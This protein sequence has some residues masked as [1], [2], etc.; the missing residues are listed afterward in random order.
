MALP[1]NWTLPHQTLTKKMPYR[2][3]YKQCDGAIFSTEFSYSQITLSCVMLM[4]LNKDNVW[5]TDS[6]LSREPVGVWD[7]VAIVTWA[8]VWILS[9]VIHSRSIKWEDMGRNRAFA[10]SS[11]PFPAWILDL[12]LPPNELSLHFCFIVSAMTFPFFKELTEGGDRLRCV[13]QKD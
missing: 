10:S 7:T 3:T 11:S 12:A 4:K 6:N 13:T 5:F 2:L 8:K 9:S 1:V